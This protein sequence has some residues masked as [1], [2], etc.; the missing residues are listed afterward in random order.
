M[1]PGAGPADRAGAGVVDVAGVRVGVHRVDRGGG[2]FQRVG[3]VQGTEAENAARTMLAM[4]VVA[5]TLFVGIT[6][7]VG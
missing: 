6:A 7:G 3:G 1:R 4:G 5:I 2:D